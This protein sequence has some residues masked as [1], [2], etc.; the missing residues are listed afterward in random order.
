M[1]F[2]WTNR[3][4]NPVLRRLLRTAAGRW[5]GRD[6]LLIRYTGRRTGRPREVVTQYARSGNTVWV[7]VGAANR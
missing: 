2:W 4:A 3:V 1:G 6:L 7:L 5:L